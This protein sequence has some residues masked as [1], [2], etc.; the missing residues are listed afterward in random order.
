MKKNLFL[1][2]ALVL[3]F[4]SQADWSNPQVLCPEEILP[5]GIPCLDLSLVKNPMVDFPVA[6]SA[7]EKTEW[8]NLHSSDLK[9]CRNQEVLRRETLRP[10]SFTPLQIELAWMGTNGGEEAQEKYQSVME[11]AQKFGV[12]PQILLGAL[13]QESLLANLGITP[14]GGNYSCGMAQL[15]ISEWC[16]GMKTLTAQER[17]ALNWPEVSCGTLPSESVAPFYSLAVKKLGSR[18]EY[19]MTS[20]DFEGITIADVALEANPK[21]FEAISSFVKNCQNIHYSIPFKAFNLRS[22]FNQFVPA[23]LKKAEVYSSFSTF[24]RS[25]AQS[26][27]SSYYPLHTGWLLAVAI[28]NAGPIE[29]KLLEH[30]YQIQDNQFPSMTP[31]DLIEALHWGGKVKGSRVYFTGQNQETYSQ[32]WYKSCVVQR[33]VARVIQHVSA[34]GVTIAQSLEKSPCD[35]K[36]VPTYRQNSSGIRD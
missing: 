18:P 3:P 28:Y 19:R 36:K 20:M 7:V 29:T 30:Y 8:I 27:P 9:L 24:P 35:K 23:S 1:A 13:T 16:Q 10:G 34:P 17:A 15:N 33:H 12:P 22:I 6:M 32:L 21:K 25:C 11:A 14:D 5:Q 26:Y 4:T 31:L 2:L